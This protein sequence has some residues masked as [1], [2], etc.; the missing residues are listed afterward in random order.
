MAVKE[1][2]NAPNVQRSVSGSASG[3]NEIDASAATHFWEN[4]SR[5]TLAVNTPTERERTS[6]F[7]FYTG[8]CI[9][10]LADGPAQWF[11]ANFEM[12]MRFPSAATPVAARLY[13]FAEGKPPKCHDVESLNAPV[14]EGSRCSIS[15]IGE[16]P[17]VCYL[18]QLKDQVTTQLF[19]DCLLGLQK[20]ITKLSG[21]SHPKNDEVLYSQAEDGQR[22]IPDANSEYQEQESPNSEADSLIDVSDELPFDTEEDEAIYLGARRAL[23]AIDSVS[24]KLAVMQS[25][26]DKFSQVMKAADSFLG[27]FNGVDLLEMWSFK[28]AL[29]KVMELSTAFEKRQSSNDATPTTPP[30]PQ[31]QTSIPESVKEMMKPITYSAEALEKF[32]D[33]ATVPDR[34]RTMEDSHMSE[35]FDMDQPEWVSQ[36]WRPRSEYALYSAGT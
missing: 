33:R 4:L 22:A 5:C 31:R 20:T 19:A 8:Q 15:S 34:G 21:N 10:H 9:M 7:S 32:K 17:R 26:S 36:V 16:G 27:H 2:P 6:A 1:P 18:L 35:G 28:T 13:L 14:M 12:K 23:D 29:V 30:L 24:K 3:L 11:L 25:E